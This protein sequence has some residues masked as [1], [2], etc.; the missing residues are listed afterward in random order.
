MLEEASHWI[1]KKYNFISSV[2][3]AELE[4]SDCN[5][6]KVLDVGSGTGEM[7]ALPLSR[8]FKRSIQLSAFDTDGASLCYLRTQSNKE[9]LDNIIIVDDCAMCEGC[10]Y[11]VIIIS[12][13]IEHV[14]EPLNFLRQFAK[15]LDHRGKM[16]V[17][18]PNGYGYKEF[19]SM[20]E[21]A[22][23]LLKVKPFLKRLKWAILRSKTPR[24]VPR[25]TL[26]VS[27]HVNFFSYSQ[28][29]ALFAKAGLR[30]D[31]YEGREF[32]GGSFISRFSIDKSK[33]LLNLNNLLGSRLPPSLVS[34]W[35]F[36]LSPNVHSTAVDNTDGLRIGTVQN[37]YVKL[38]RFINMRRYGLPVPFEQPSRSWE[39]FKTS[40]KRAE[41]R[42]D[43]F[44]KLVPCMS[45]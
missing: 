32:V 39:L 31:R 7:V 2:I 12:E 19:D 14:S 22:I 27:P 1:L 35:M 36:V 9:N 28:V 18:L 24:S 15:L 26:A 45:E 17:T 40:D 41:G 23:E 33:A 20:I 34:G 13:V 6:I 8:G 44:R 30:I 4:R 37:W 5:F 42:S 16:I 11:Q 21:G 29:K 43:S 10:K 3:K 38:K 25:D